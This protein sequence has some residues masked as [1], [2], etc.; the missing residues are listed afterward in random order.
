MDYCT[1]TK[2]KR[3]NIKLIN[4][5]KIYLRNK[6]KMKKIIHIFRDRVQHRGAF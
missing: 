3:K 5:E 4:N 1:I 6:K 2:Y